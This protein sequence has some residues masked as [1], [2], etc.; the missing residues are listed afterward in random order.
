[1]TVRNMGNKPSKQPRPHVTSDVGN[2]IGSQRVR[3]RD[4]IRDILGFSKSKTKEVDATATNLTV[5]A[6]NLPQAVGL[7][8]TSS[9]SDV[10]SMDNH[11]LASTP[12]IDISLPAPVETKRI[13][14]I[15]LENLP[16]SMMKT[17][18]PAVQDRIEV[19]QQLA[20]CSALLLHGS[21]PPQATTAELEEQT[22]N[23]AITLQRFPNLDKKELD[24]LAQMD[25]NLPAK[26]RISWLG[27]RMVDEF[28]KDVLKDSTEIAEI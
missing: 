7:P 15:F 26:E 13:S 27:T 12:L 11:A 24:W 19:T 5:S 1:M 20:Y 22:R 9:A 16:A 17:E 8:T 2:G 4:V 3:K 10:H 25:E 28:A 14:A 6:Q 23:P 21:S 18:L